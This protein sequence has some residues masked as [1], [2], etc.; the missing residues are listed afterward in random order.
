MFHSFLHVYQRVAICKWR[1]EW[2]TW[3]FVCRNSMEIQLNRPSPKSPCF[4]HVLAQMKKSGFRAAVA[5]AKK[6]SCGNE[7]R[8]DDHP[9]HV[10][11]SSVVRPKKNYPQL[12]TMDGILFTILLQM[13]FTLIPNYDS[14]W[15]SCEA[16]KKGF[17]LVKKIVVP[18]E[19]LLG[20]FLK[21]GGSPSHHGFQ[22]KTGSMTWMI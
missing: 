2:G 20:G 14:W 22:Y 3:W 5:G 16:N 19:Q 11:D 13:E 7:E 1:F 12:A 10:I 18:R 4:L 17:F 21:W 6:T 8:A 9:P 15:N